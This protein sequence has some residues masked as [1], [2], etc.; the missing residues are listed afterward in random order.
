MSGLSILLRR[1]IPE[2]LSVCS[3]PVELGLIQ[4]LPARVFPLR[5]SALLP[6]RLT[7]KL[8]GSMPEVIS[9]PLLLSLKNTSAKL[10]YLQTTCLTLTSSSNDFILCFCLRSSTGKVENVTNC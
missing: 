10:S 1:E 3:A 2:V 6:I 5:T 9:S 7:A 4:T 8:L